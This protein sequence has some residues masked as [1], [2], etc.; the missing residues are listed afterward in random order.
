MNA[1]NANKL[2]NLSVINTDKLISWLSDLINTWEVIVGSVGIA[3]VICIFYLILVRF[4]AAII[5]Y[6]TI[7]LLLCTLAG[8]GYLFQ[9]R[10]DY[11]KDLNDEN[12]VLAMKVLCGL[13]YS[14]AGLWLLV[15][16]FMCNKIRLS[17]ALVEV[18][19]KY[20]AGNCSIFLIPFLFFFFAIGFYVYWV[21]L[22]VFI[23]ATG[24][25]KSTSGFIAIIEW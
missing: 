13:F 4:C 18:T 16:L 10:I 9:Y 19:A 2:I 1:N 5:A 17:I 8:L 25:I 14:L 21:A 6:V 24:T 3:F 20:L 12:Y 22:S 15:I 11:Y 23:Y 7:F